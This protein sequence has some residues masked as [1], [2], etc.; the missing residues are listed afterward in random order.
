MG[1]SRQEYQS[2]LPCPP[3]GNLP[4]PRIELASLTSPALASGLFTTSTTWEA[5]VCVCVCVGDVCMCVWS[6]CVGGCVCGVCVCGGG[7]CVL[8]IPRSLQGVR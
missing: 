1:F 2:G 5:H 7:V 8:I 6:V 3:L 4:D